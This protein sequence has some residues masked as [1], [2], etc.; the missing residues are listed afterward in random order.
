MISVKLG[1]GDKCGTFRNMVG[2]MGW[3]VTKGVVAHQFMVSKRKACIFS[4]DSME[5][6]KGKK[7]MEWE[8]HVSWYAKYTV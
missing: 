7:K 1:V 5:C 6:F 4:K 3:N 2:K 8:F